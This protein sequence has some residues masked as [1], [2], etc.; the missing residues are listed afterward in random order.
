M[1]NIEKQIHESN[2]SCLF[3]VFFFV[4]FFFFFFF[5]VLFF[6]VVFFKVFKCILFKISDR[7]FASSIVYAATAFDPDK[8]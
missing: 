7:H 5:F 1:F 2:V 3:V 8:K 4:L 6:V